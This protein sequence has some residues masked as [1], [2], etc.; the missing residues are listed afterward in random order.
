[1]S[2]P[3]QPG[4]PG[5]DQELFKLAIAGLICFFIVI[6]I[7]AA[8][9]MRINAFIGAVTWL[10]TLPFATAA[11]YLPFLQD[12]PFIGSW[13]FDQSLLAHKF[14]GQGGYAAM[15]PEQRTAVLVAGGRA[16]SILYGASFVWIALNGKE[17]RVDQKY[18]TSH[19]LESMIWVQSENWMTSRIAR[20]M[21]PLKGKEISARRIAESVAGKYGEGAKMPGF[22]IPRR[23]IALQPG[24]WNRA[25]RPE[26]WLIANGLAFDPGRYSVMTGGDESVRDSDFEFRGRWEE[27]DLETVSEVLSAQ[28]RTPW[29]GPADLR[30]CHKA[31]FAVMALFYAYDIDGGNKLLSELGILADAM[32]AK[33]GSMDGAL[34]SERGM[35]AKIDKIV[36]GTPGKT[37]AR[38]A[39]HHAWVESAFPTFLAKA[40]KDRGV[41]PPAAFLWLKAEDRLMW[42]ILNNVGNEA[43]MIE[44]AGA[45][46]H[47]RAETQISR[48]IRR[49]A[50]YQAARALLEDYLDMTPERIDLRKQ[51]A[52]RHRTPG[53]QIEMI[54]GSILGVE[55]AADIDGIDG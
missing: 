25:L 1:M 53:D 29:T 36:L 2:G 26:E 52:V 6:A 55:T 20:H 41:L 7:I 3:S 9:E 45:L 17:F 14:L 11:R 48:P 42:Y 28:L 46:A 10:H 33:R 18:R 32:K 40:R 43:V 15:T 24:T 8:Q 37:L 12:I 47:S 16:A 44:A 51:R 38:A 31:L 49:P 23:L 4:Q 19:T 39:G 54:R 34:L 21:N 22:A 27:L 30:P 50:V 5:D 35:A 13:L